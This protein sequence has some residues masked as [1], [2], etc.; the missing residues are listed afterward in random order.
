MLSLH[1]NEYAAQKPSECDMGL[2]SGN[3]EGATTNGRPRSC[4]RVHSSRSFL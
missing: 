3:N 4:H 1:A 2:V